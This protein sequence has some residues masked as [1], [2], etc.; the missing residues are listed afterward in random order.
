MRR[1]GKKEYYEWADFWQDSRLLAKRIKK[2]GKKF[3]QIYGLPRGGLIPAVCLS[4]LLNLPLILDI[5]KVNL[6]T[7]V[8]DD[9]VDTGGTFEKFFKILSLKKPF[10]ASLYY[11]ESS[12]IRPN[13]YV[14][15]KKKW[16][17]FPWET[18]ATSKYDF[19]FST[20]TGD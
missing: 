16:V 8:V 1:K 13:I 9:I 11:N 14:R 6:G 10:I 18:E 20:S 7:L 19:S 3:T 12:K 5:K 15:E 4:H 17:V 2:S